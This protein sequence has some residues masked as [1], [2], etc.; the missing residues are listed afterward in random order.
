MSD[1]LD[2]PETMES[3]VSEAFIRSLDADELVWF[4]DAVQGMILADQRVDEEEINFLRHLIA[5]LSDKNEAERLVEM[6][7]ERKQAELPYSGQMERGVAFEILTV[8]LNLAL[9][10]G[11]LR[12]VEAEYFKYACRRLGFDNA[13]SKDMLVWAQKKLELEVEYKRLRKISK[14]A[15]DNYKQGPQSILDAKKDE[16]KKGLTEEKRLIPQ[17]N[18]LLGKYVNCLICKQPNIPFWILRARTM[19][20]QANLFG[21]TIYKKSREGKD[22]CDYNLIHVATCPKCQFASNDIRYFSSGQEIAK[23]FE[24]GKMATE[25]IETLP[26]RQEKLPEDPLAL[27]AE[28][29]SVENAILSYDFAILTFEQMYKIDGKHPTLLKLISLQMVQ[30]E[31]LMNAKKREAAEANLKKVAESLGEVFEYLEGE[32]IFR[33]AA[34]LCFI[35][36]YFKDYVAVGQYMGFLKNYSTKGEM[37][38]SSAEYKAFMLANN[39]VNEAYSDREQYAYDKLESFH[40]S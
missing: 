5:M 34:L 38:S 1:N 18:S 28:E 2:T 15:K 16:M 23:G 4:V 17:N 21:V 31:L 36:M 9:S 22:F 35:K 8:L 11:K 26:A 13:F 10:D 24:P 3:I 25:W 40:L 14:S 32:S 6:I 12:T 37:D 33:S 27:N 39:R 20:T 7:K 29:R 19:Q 30:S